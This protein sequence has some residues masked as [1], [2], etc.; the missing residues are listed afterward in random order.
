MTRR[1]DLD[2]VRVLAFCLLVIYHVG[3]CYVT[4]DWHVKSADAG[5]SIEP[6]MVL[7]SPW[8]LSLLFLVSGVATAFLLGKQ[9][10][11]FL[12]A[13]SWRLLVPLFFGMLVIVPPQAYYEVLENLPGGYHDGYLAFWGRYLMADP[14]FCRGDDCLDV[15]TWNHLWFVAYLWAYTMLLGLALRFLPVFSTRVVHRVESALSG[16]GLLIW[17]LIWLVAARL[18]LFPVFDSTHGLFDDW[19]NHAQYFSVFL[20]GFS[21]ARSNSSWDAIEASRRIAGL[22]AIACGGFLSWYFSTYSGDIPA[23]TALLNVQR[24]VWAVMTWSV[25]VAVLG[26]ARHIAPGD[27]ATLRYLSDAIFPVYILHQ[28][29]IIV[30]AYNLKP[31]AIAPALEG[32]LLIVATF[33]LC[34]LGYEIVRRIAILRPLFGLKS[35]RSGVTDANGV[36]RMV[37]RGD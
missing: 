30:L 37:E 6:L 28:T 13:R 8:R 36:Q 25:I 27:S 12:R 1:H 2:W 29:V 14:S 24:V 23:P 26:Y 17:P 7:S 5:P 4:W 31:F 15:P 18:V 32:P 3:M 19:Y 21:I 33:A 35:M 11:G 9:R 16:A 10:E 20:I 34:F 22:V